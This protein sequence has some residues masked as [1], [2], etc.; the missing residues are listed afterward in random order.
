MARVESG[1]PAGVTMFPPRSKQAVVERADHSSAKSLVATRVTPES[2]HTPPASLAVT[3]RPPPPLPMHPQ[4][5]LLTG[6]EFVQMF[7]ARP[8]HLNR[9]EPGLEHEIGHRHIAGLVQCGFPRIGREL[10]E[11]FSG[12]RH[13]ERTSLRGSD[14]VS[15]FREFCRIHRPLIRLLSTSNR[16]SPKVTVESGHRNSFDVA[17]QLPAANTRSPAPSSTR[18]RPS[19]SDC[20]PHLLWITL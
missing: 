14:G 19:R 10:R 15:S 16:K 12:I 20:C 17:I 2:A 18:A 3:H 4:P 6:N 9:A 5:P 11:E 7:Y 13:R 1:R 8:P